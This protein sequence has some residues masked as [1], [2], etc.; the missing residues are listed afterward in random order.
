M[1]SARKEELRFVRLLLALGAATEEGERFVAGA[2]S[3]SSRRVRELAADGVVSLSADALSPSAATAGWLRRNL[4]E[5]DRFAD[6]HREI[7]RV[8]DGT[9][10][11]LGDDLLARLARPDAKNRTAFLSAAQFEAG[12]RLRRMWRRAG[13]APRLTMHYAPDHMPGSGGGQ[14]EMGDM[15]AD[16]R[17]RF[18]AL[19]GELPPDCARVVFDVA[20]ELRGLQQIEADA[21]W[22]RRSAKLVLRIGLEQV[23]RRMGLSDSAE[24]PERGRVRAEMHGERVAM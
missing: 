3:L 17:R 11:N 22:P 12:L 20:A 9:R 4:I 5:G 19:L 7:A 23:A 14:A 6:Q 1:P 13:I 15:A 8:P 10:V 2:A 16:A 24:G 21:G 18:N